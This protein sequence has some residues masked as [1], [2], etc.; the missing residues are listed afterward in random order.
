MT[1]NYSNTGTNTHQTT[2]SQSKILVQNQISQL[3]S[4]LRLESGVNQD[5]LETNR[6]VLESI[7]EMGLEQERL[8]EVWFVIVDQGN[9]IVDEWVLDISYTDERYELVSPTRETIQEEVAYYGTNDGYKAFIIPV[10]DGKNIFNMPDG[11][12]LEIDSFGGPGVNVDIG[13][14]R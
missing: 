8:D 14:L 5:F 10:I 2:K 3:Y 9:T 7:F 1:R 6:D 12:D 11:D 4:L 13:H